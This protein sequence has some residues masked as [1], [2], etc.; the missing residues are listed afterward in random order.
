MAAPTGA[1]PSEVMP[2]ITPESAAELKRITR[3][4]KRRRNDTLT[5]TG[6]NNIPC[7][8]PMG[9]GEGQGMNL[10]E[11]ARLI[12]ILQETITQQSRIIKE[13]SHTIETLRTGQA[14]L[15]SELRALKG[16]VEKAAAEI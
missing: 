4:S 1:S 11:I 14:E 16:P 10:D 13:Q 12:A 3:S 8:Q 2:T 7:P 15:K 9:G 5:F 6:A